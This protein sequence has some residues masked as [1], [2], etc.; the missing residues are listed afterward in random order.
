MGCNNCKNRVSGGTKRVAVQDDGFMWYK[1][2]DV[3]SYCGKGCDAVYKNWWE[4]NDNKQVDQHTSTPECFETT[5]LYRDLQKISDQLD[6][7]LNI[8]N[9]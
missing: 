4:T 2:V 8:V 7:M 5:D 9:K 3:P 6:K 1:V